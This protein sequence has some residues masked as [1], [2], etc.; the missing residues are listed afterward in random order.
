MSKGSQ[1]VPVR[2]PMELLDLINA[3]IESR[4]DASPQ[5]PMNLSSWIR[6]AVREKL[7][8]LVRGRSK[9]KTMPAKAEATFVCFA[10]Q[11]E[12]PISRIFPGEPRLDDT[13]NLCKLCYMTWRLQ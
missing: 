11:Q 1:V 8:H 7:R 9:A 2:I 10:C 6:A 13:A 12:F 4:N 5:E 3:A